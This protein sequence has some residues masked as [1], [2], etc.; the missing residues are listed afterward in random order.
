MWMIK[1]ALSF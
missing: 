1:V